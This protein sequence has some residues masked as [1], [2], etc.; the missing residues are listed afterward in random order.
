[1]H[2]WPLL[3]PQPLAAFDLFVLAN[4]TIAGAERR[5]KNGQTKATFKM[6]SGLLFCALCAN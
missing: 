6:H 3:Q 5:H 2:L 4:F 1:M